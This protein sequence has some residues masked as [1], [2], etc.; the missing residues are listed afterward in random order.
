M[1]AAFRQIAIVLL[2]L[3]LM[4]SLG[5][6]SSFSP[7]EPPMAD[8]TF[9]EVLT[10]LHLAATRVQIYEDTTLTTL[11]DSIF[12]HYDVPRERFERTLAYYSKHPTTYQTLYEAMQDS[13][14]AEQTRLQGYPYP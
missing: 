10:E 4:G 3:G 8:S 12:A 9:I 14:N 5:A 13:L 7:E 11:Q 6:C 1:R 2:G